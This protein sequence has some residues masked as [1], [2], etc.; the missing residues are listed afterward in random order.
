MKQ[1]KSKIT[2][3][4]IWILLCGW[5]MCMSSCGSLL[6]NP[7][8]KAEQVTV[9]IKQPK[10]KDEKYCNNNFNLLSLFSCLW[11]RD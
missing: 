5:I 8:N 7:S 6:Y 11:A 10:K 1:K 3:V 2:T 4:A 9:T